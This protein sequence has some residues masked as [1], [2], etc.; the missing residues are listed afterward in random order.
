[1]RA[2]LS[3]L[4]ALFVILPSTAKAG[5]VESAGTDVAV[6]LPLLAGGLVLAKRDWTGAAELTVDTVGTVGTTYLL[7]KL[8]REQR[9][10]KS[11]F[12]SFPSDTSALAF[13][14]AQFVWDRYGWEYGV[15]AY[16]AAGFV[17]FSRVDAKKHHWWD[18]AASAGIAFTF[19]K[20]FTTEYR[21]PLDYQ[22]SA[23]SDGVYA[24]LH[25][26]F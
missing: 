11:D 16:L 20:I 25:Y 5:G 10:D 15:P 8:I 24:S 9:P 12:E 6:A 1:M 26:T 13:A 19:S 3:A 2:A 4:L 7:K 14:P 23:S 17:G 18:V 22:V 21:K